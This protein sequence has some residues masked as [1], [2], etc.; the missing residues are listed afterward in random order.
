VEQ[1]PNIQVKCHTAVGV[2]YLK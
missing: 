1:L 2:A